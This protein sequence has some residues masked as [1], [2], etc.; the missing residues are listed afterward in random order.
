MGANSDDFKALVVSII[1]KHASPLAEDAITTHLSR[2]GKYLSVTVTIT[3][4]SQD[5][6]DAIYRELSAN[7]R[8][9][10]ML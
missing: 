9:L 4:E 6:L 7:K 2:G 8:V 5:Q 3:A 10:M 1:E